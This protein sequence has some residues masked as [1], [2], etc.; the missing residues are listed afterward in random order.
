[1]H[2]TTGA[3]PAS[4]STVCATTRSRSSSA[5][6]NTGTPVHPAWKSARSTPA[7]SAVPRSRANASTAPGATIT[8][9]IPRCSRGSR[10]PAKSVQPA[11]ITSRK[12]S[13]IPPFWPQP[14]N[15]SLTPLSSPPHSGTAPS[16]P[17]FLQ[18]AFP[19]ANAV[20]LAPGIA[21]DPGDHPGLLPDPLPRLVITTHWHSDHAGAVH[22]LQSRGAR[23]A[24]SAAEAGRIATWSPDPGR[25]LW[26]RQHLDRYWVDRPLHPGD[27]LETGLTRWTILSLPGHTAEQIGLHDPATDTIITGDALHATDIGW[28]DLDADPDALDQAEATIELIDRLRPRL[29]YPGHGPAIHDVPDAIARARRRLQDWRRRPDRLAFHACKRILTHAL[30]TRDGIPRPAM[31]PYLLDCPWFIDHAARLGLAPDAFVLVL[32]EEMLRSSAAAWEHDRLVASGPYRGKGAIRL[33][34][35]SPSFR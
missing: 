30:M 26:L 14:P 3:A 12:T 32:L 11:G 35:A 8:A 25:A 18:R 5:T 31:A 19:S 7:A 9:S 28:L 24:A 33:Q 13:N 20:L 4:G 2:A 15:H 34:P 21:V 10:T 23:V 22:A 29:A 27:V 1:M 17:R 6:G 16:M